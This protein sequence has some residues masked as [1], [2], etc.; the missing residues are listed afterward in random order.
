MRVTWTTLLLLALSCALALPAIAEDE[1]P[2]PASEEP[3]PKA[4]PD[5]EVPVYSIEYLMPVEDHAP[6]GWKLGDGRAPDGSPTEDLLTQMSEDCKCSLDDDNFYVETAVLKSGSEKVGFAMVD[7]DRSVHAFRQKVDA[8]AAQHGWKVL[9]LGAKGRLL[10]V[11]PGAKQAAAAD[12]LGEHIVYQLGELAMN[13]VRAGGTEKEAGRRT[14]EAYVA[15]MRSMKDKV[16]VADAIE[17]ILRWIESAPE[18]P[19][20]DAKRDQ[21]KVDAAKALWAKALTDGVAFPPRGSVLVWCAGQLGGLL[22]EQK[23]KAVLG[24]AMRTLK[25]AV[26]HEHQAKTNA[27]RYT[28]RYNL[29]CALVRSEEREAALDMLEGALK[30][31]KDMPVGFYQAQYKHIAEKDTD[32]GPIRN[33]PRF[34]GFMKT[35]QPP[36]PRNPHHK[37]NPHG[38]PHGK[39]KGDDKPKDDGEKKDGE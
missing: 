34:R 22:L 14:V 2:T 6:E 9:E 27:Q 38:N 10:I 16:G 31:L 32:M 33:T 3:A 5:P 12:A 28:H 36:A 39:G 35:Y 1:P 7:V 23:D 29:A 30:I 19:G 24:E 17:G 18:K 15:A 37:G 21:A 11:G 4:Q 25:I 13:R 8:G 26:E 20:K